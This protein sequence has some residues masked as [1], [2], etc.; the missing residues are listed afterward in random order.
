MSE[1]DN[2][3]NSWKILYGEERERL[4]NKYYIIPV[5]NRQEL[6][7]HLVQ[8]LVDKGYTREDFNKATFRKAIEEACTTPIKNKD[9]LNNWKRA[10]LADLDVV[11]TTFWLDKSDIKEYRGDKLE[12]LRNKTYKPAPS[13]F[14]EESQADS[15]GASEEINSP[16]HGEPLDRSVFKNMPEPNIVYDEEFIEL[17][18]IKDNE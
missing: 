7:A 11:V 16:Q 9:K 4:G 6:L 14:K 3:L 5:A 15:A 13:S 17:L 12:Q 8:T 2:I 10:V 18:G 1:L